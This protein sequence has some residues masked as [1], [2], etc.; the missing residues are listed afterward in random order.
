MSSTW[1]RWVEKLLGP[2]GPQ[3]LRVSQS[4]LSLSNY[5]IIA[6]LQY[7]EVRLG[8]I[9][10]G[11]SAALILFSLGGALLFYGLIRSGL[12]LKLS[13]EPAL[14]QPQML[15][16]MVVVC[17]AYAISGPVRGAVLMI[18]VLIQVYG[19]FILRPRQARAIS[20]AGMVMLSGAVLVMTILD[21]QRYD[22]RVEALHLVFAGVTMTMVLVLAGR[23]GRLRERLSEQKAELAEALERIQT[24]ARRDALTGLLN[25]RAMLELLGHE[26]RAQQRHHQCMTL[27][28]IDLDHFKSINDQHGHRVGDLVLKAL[29]EVGKDALRGG[30]VLSRWGGEEFLLMLPR[31]PVDEAMRCVQRLRDVL[32]QADLPGA[33][34]GLRIE[35]SAGLAD[36]R[37]EADIEA[38]I[39][40]A[41]IAMYRAKAA[42]RNRS[43]C[44]GPV[45]TVREVLA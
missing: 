43:E 28:L 44:G 24:L 37:H 11:A 4:L 8:M 35:F 9:Q 5:V 13:R 19:I 29:A 39:E 16:A 21:P 10:P 1:Q 41:D 27:A 31:T 38:A 36:C 26:C 7:T 15:F 18:L 30:D 3:R 40:Q 32:A 20:L 17:L 6:V 14:T 2:V 42:G 25:R 34:P 23:L 22:L 12:N 33:P 45:H